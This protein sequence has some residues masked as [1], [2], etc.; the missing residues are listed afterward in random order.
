MATD[1][2]GKVSLGIDTQSMDDVFAKLNNIYDQEKMAADDIHNYKLQLAQDELNFRINNIN[3]EEKQRMDAEQKALKRQIANGKDSFTIKANS[4]KKVEKMEADWAKKRQAII[5]KY[6]GDENAAMGDLAKV[7]KF[8]KKKIEGEKKAAEAAGKESE[9]WVKRQAEIY[10]REENKRQRDATSSAAASDFQKG[11]IYGMYQTLRDGE[12]SALTKATAFISSLAKA[13]EQQ[14]DTIAGKKGA[15]DTRM[16]GSKHAA[17]RDYI[18]GGSSYWDNMSKTITGVAGVSPLIKQENVV[19]NLETLVGKGIAYNVEQRAFLATVKDKIATTFDSFDATLLRMIRIQQAD[20]TA[21]RLG[22]ESALN[23]FLNEMYETSEYL[24]DLASTVRGSLDE[25]EALMGAADAVALEYQVQKWMGSLYSVGMSR[26]AVSGIAGAL[27]QLAAGDLSGL[28]GN[29]GNLMVMAANHA[30]L[31]IADILAQGLDDSNANK[32]MQAM[33]DYL[34]QIADSSATS[35]VV[36][37]QLAKV[38]GISASDLRAA[39]NLSSS[40]GAVASSMLSYGG[41]YGQLEKMMGSMYQRTSIGEMMTNAWSNLN[42]TMAAGMANNPVLYAIYKAATLLDDFAGGIALPDIKVMGSGVNLQTT[43]ADLMRVT[44]MSGSIIQGIGQMI[45]AGSGGGFSPLGM[46][47]AMGISNNLTT[48]SRGTGLTKKALGGAGVSESGSMAGNGSSEDV[49]NQTMSSATDEQKSKMAEAKEDEEND[50]MNKDLN[51]SI[52]QIY[53]LL[54]RVISGSEAFSVKP[55]WGTTWS[56]G[57]GAG[58]EG[59][60]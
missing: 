53:D 57:S 7:D 51:S 30:G 36:Q 54:Q 31:S 41:A 39:K 22:M 43:V 24:T 27:G 3:K 13:L 58:G 56:N 1:A 12:G 19:A 17:N 46:L 23:A 40:S 28:T 42:Y 59:G 35:R 32:L 11:N 55:A 50:L 10:R 20:S 9:K 14:V 25:V 18:W 8:Y 44:A 6:G 2:G 45:A 16:Q 37:Q 49:L 29:Y 5:A 15:I 21:G 47:K 33:V 48:V 26:N 52:I 60:Y 4:Q 38:Y 34:S